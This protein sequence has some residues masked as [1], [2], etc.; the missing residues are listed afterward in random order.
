MDNETYL[1]F[2]RKWLNYLL[3]LIGVALLIALMYNIGFSD[4]KESLFKA[5]LDFVILAALILGVLH[6]FR[7]IRWHLF[8]NKLKLLP[9]SKLY[10]IGQAINEIAPTGSGELVKILIAKKRYNISRSTTLI[11]TAMERFLDVVYLL[12]FALMGLF[13]L[14]GQIGVF[15]MM[16]PTLLILILILLVG[17][18]LFKPSVVGHIRKIL[19]KFKNKVV[20]MLAEVAGSLETSLFNFHLENKR[21][22]I[23][24]V[25]LTVVTWLLDGLTHFCLIRAFGYQVEL[26]YI[27][28]IV[29]V[30]WLLGTFSFLPGGL[31]VREGTYVYLLETQSIP[32][33]IGASVILIQR[34]LLYSYF[35]TGALVSLASYKIKS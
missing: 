11:A 10:F 16:L 22:L 9:S 14:K 35:Y 12:I 1:K 21:G 23:A 8:L 5:H 24:G 26:L 3:L 20:V 15:E 2:K 27:Y 4:I 18:I 17:F 31:G 25:I 30:A 19:L 29:A 13:V 32:P 7:A 33:P 34:F 28:V 6:F